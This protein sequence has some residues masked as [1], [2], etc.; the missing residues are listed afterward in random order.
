MDVEIV[1]MSATQ[2]A[3]L[4]AVIAGATELLT[5]LRAK[6][7]WAAATIVSAAVIGG[8]LGIYW[9]IDF[10]SGIAAGLGV[11]GTIATIGSFGR[12]SEARPSTV[13]K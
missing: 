9:G 10:V 1:S 11:S 2:I 8:L 7:Y 3:L 4:G 5:R 12:K 13:L 6:D